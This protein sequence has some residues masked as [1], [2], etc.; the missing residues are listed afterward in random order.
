[1]MGIVLKAIYIFLE[2]YITPEVGGGNPP[3]YRNW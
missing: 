1:M 3:W 2:A